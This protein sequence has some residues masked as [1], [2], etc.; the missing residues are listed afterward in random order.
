[1]A[2]HNFVV[3]S[4]QTYSSTIFLSYFLPS[5]WKETCRIN[6]KLQILISKYNYQKFYSSLITNISNRQIFHHIW[7]LQSNMLEKLPQRRNKCCIWT[8]TGQRFLFELDWYYYSNGNSS[9]Q[10]YK[11][12]LVLHC[13]N[14][15]WKNI[16]N[17]SWLFAVIVA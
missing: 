13:V 15:S 17:L 11:K 4:L 9:A 8:L 5:S 3:L 16:Y 14:G 12:V 10:T 2:V 7:H 6:R 1:M